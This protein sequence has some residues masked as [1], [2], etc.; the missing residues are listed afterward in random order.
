MSKDT[1]Q[2]II[3]VARKLFIQ[4]GYAGTSIRLIASKSQINLSMISYYFKNKEGLYIAILQEQMQQ[5]YT[6]LQHSQ[7]ISENPKE[8]LQHYITHIFKLYKTKPNFARMALSTLNE[9]ASISKN[10]RGE[11][12]KKLLGFVSSN[13]QKGVDMGL[14]RDDIALKDMTFMLVSIIHFYINLQNI[15]NSLQLELH[16]NDIQNAL[17][18]Y[19]RGIEK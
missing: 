10:I 15:K 6:I 18:I 11:F 7:N 13:L 19:F 12:A 14:F 5:V 17:N 1:K 2:K 9:P 16:Y 8:C 3:D 4:K